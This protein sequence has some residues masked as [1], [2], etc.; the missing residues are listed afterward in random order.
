MV[1]L[2]EMKNAMTDLQ[3]AII[4][5]MLAEETAERP[6]AVMVSKMLV[7]NAMA[8]PTALKPVF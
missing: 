4:C 6:N 2:K 3:T 5:Q 7:S 1:L 8:L